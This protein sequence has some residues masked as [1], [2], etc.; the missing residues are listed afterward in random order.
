VDLDISDKSTIYMNAK[1]GESKSQLMS[2]I[3]LNKFKIEQ[4]LKTKQEH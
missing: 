3:K 2:L 1:N 4:D